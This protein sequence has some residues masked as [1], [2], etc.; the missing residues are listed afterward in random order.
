MGWLYVGDTKVEDVCI[1][2]DGACQKS[3]GAEINH[4]IYRIPG[5][6]HSLL[7]LNLQTGGF[8]YKE[9]LVL[10]KTVS[11]DK[12]E[13]GYVNDA[14]SIWGIALDLKRTASYKM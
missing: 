14:M 3:S 13:T 10:G 9:F 5:W 11:V 12:S 6:K 4:K 2:K 7:E 1:G 8:D